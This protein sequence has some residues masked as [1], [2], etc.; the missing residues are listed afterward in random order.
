MAYQKHGL[1]GY[2][3]ADRQFRQRS[4][5]END[6][7]AEA[8]YYAH[9]GDK[10]RSLEQLNLAYQQHCDGM[11]FLNVEPVYDDLRDDRRFKELLSKL[12]L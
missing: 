9:M 7:V 2:W 12:R 11:Q 8:M 10:N 4:N 5:R 1:P 6:P 3:H